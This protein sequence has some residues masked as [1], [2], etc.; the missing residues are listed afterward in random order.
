MCVCICIDRHYGD[1]GPLLMFVPMEVVIST[2]LETGPE[3]KSQ[4]I[5]GE[6]R[7]K[8]IAEAWLQERNH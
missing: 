1:N 7:P 4:V 2:D 3:A 5:W 8:M 6:R